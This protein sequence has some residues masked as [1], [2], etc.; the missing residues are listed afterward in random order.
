[1]KARVIM[2]WETDPSVF[3]HFNGNHLAYGI[4]GD[5]STWLDEIWIADEKF[6]ATLENELAGLEFPPDR[7]IAIAVNSRVNLAILSEI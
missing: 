2:E 1:M 6:F 5:G 4:N 7:I 3:K